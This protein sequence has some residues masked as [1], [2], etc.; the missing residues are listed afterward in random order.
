MEEAGN[1]AGMEFRVKQVKGLVQDEG[2]KVGAKSTALGEAFL[3]GEVVP[4]TI[5]INVP[6]D[7]GSAVRRGQKKGG[8]GGSVSKW[9][10]SGTHQ[11][12]H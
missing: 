5:V 2:G 11:S 7:V 9:Q 6:A 10:C 12:R 1:S 3:S 4:P 8:A